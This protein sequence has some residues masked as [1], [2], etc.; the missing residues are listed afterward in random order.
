MSNKGFHTFTMNNGHVFLDGTEIKCVEG[1]R[2]SV[3]SSA[4]LPIGQARLELTMV[5]DY[6]ESDLDHPD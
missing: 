1:L 4:D 5:V 2:L 6:W 3:G